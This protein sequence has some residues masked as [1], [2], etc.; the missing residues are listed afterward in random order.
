M[1]YLVAEGHAQRVSYTPDLFTFG[2]GRH[3][4]RRA[5]WRVLWLPGAGSS[6]RAE[7]FDEFAVFQGASHFRAVARG[8]EY[9]LSA[10]GLA[11]NTAHGARGR[12]SVLSHLLDRTPPPEARVLVVHALLD[13]P[14]TTG[15]YRWTIRPGDPTVMDVELTLY[16]RVAL[17]HVG[18]APLTSMFFGPMI[19]RALMTFAPRSMTRKGWPSGTGARNGCGGPSSIRTPSDECIPRC[20]PTRL[21]AG[22]ASPS[23][24]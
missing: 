4:L 15:A 14:S 23:F 6:H 11:L 21:R 5:Q 17:A 13:S 18:L 24:Y 19:G 16:P 9:G 10:R 8:Q 12:V 7:D 3:R 22:A 1:I 20:Q 2:P